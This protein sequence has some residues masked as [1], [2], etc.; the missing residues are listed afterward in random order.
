MRSSARRRCLAY[1]HY[2]RRSSVAA[3]A[4]RRSGICHG[5][6]CGLHTLSLPRRVG[7]RKTVRCPFS[8]NPG[9]PRPR[10]DFASPRCRRRSSPAVRSRAAASPGHAAAEPDR[11]W[12]RRCDAPESP[13]PRPAPAACLPPRR[14]GMPLELCVPCSHSVSR[15]QPALRGSRSCSIWAQKNRFAGRGRPRFSRSVLPSY[16]RRNRPR[17][18]NSGTTRTTK[19]SSPPGR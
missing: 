1:R 10:S 16:S 2:W 3:A 17:R 4:R 5:A 19:S 7:G 14:R 8:R 15:R 18:C 12:R 9:T 11:R 6:D 13:M